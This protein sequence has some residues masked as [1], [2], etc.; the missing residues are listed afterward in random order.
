MKKTIALLLAV[1]T[2]LSVCACG[3]KS[4]EKPEKT[5]ELSDATEQTRE[6]TEAVSDTQAISATDEVVPQE[7]DSMTDAPMLATD[8]Y[9]QYIKNY[10]GKNCASIGYTS[11]SQKRMDKYGAGLL[12][13][14]FVTA[15]GTYV[16]IEDEEAM[17]EYVVIGQSLMPNTELKLSYQKDDEGNEYDNLVD[18]QSCE[19][20]VLAVKAVGAEDFDFTLT[21]I[22]PSPDKYTYYIADYAGRNLASC[23]YTSLGGDLRVNYGAAN[24]KF[25]IVTD[26]GSFVDPNDMEQLKNYV[27]TAQNIAPNTEMTVV[28]LKDSEGNEYSNLTESQSIE[29]IELYVKQVDEG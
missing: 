19:E 10:V 6:T 8:K 15:D 20:I 24:I 1:L 13:L 4:S 28:M 7:T 2:L 29:E 18:W 5:E 25:V 23:G 17:K 27:V 21:E 3:N 14:V 26:D 9:T 16:D 11:L 22:K 12:Q